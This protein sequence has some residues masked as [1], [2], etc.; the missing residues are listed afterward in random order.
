MNMKVKLA[1]AGI[2]AKDIK[3]LSKKG[4]LCPYSLPTTTIRQLQ[5]V[6]TIEVALKI[7]R[8]SIEIELA[9]LRSARRLLKTDW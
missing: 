7:K 3:A 2:C 6:V 8:L 5:S 4:L 1:Q 9:R